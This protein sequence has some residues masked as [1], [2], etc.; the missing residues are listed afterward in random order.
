MAGKN[1]ETVQALSNRELGKQVGKRLAPG[2]LA[3]TGLAGVLL[4]GPPLVSAITSA[5][6]A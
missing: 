4:V 3:V 1:I 6:G 2:L 5:L